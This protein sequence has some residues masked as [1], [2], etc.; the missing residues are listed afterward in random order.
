MPVLQT[1]GKVSLWQTNTNSGLETHY[2][3]EVEILI[4]GQY[5]IGAAMINNPDLQNI[6]LE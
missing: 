4:Q 3:P 1:A 2:V 5:L 6:I